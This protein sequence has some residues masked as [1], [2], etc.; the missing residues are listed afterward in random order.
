LQVFVPI[1]TI[2]GTLPKW[3][4]RSIWLE[5]GSLEGIGEVV[6]VRKVEWIIVEMMG[7]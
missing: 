5:G 7:D 3:C 4:C 2:I 6:S 1:E